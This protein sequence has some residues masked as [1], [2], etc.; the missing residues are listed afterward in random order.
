[1]AISRVEFFSP[2]MGQHV[3]YSIYLPDV[4]EGP[5][6]VLFQLHGLTDSHTAWIQYSRIVKHA[7]NYPMVIVFPDGGTGAYLNWLGHERIGKRMYE[8]LI[9]T[10][11]ANH[12]HRHYNV[13]DGP[14][15]IGGLSM[16]GYGS[17]RLG[18]KYADRF[19]S[20]WSHSSKFEWEGMIESGQFADP[21]DTDVRTHADAVNAMADKPVI[22]FDCGTEDQLIEESRRFHEHLDE[23]GLDHTYNEHSGGHTWEYWDEHVQPAL[24]QHARVLG[25]EPIVE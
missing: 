18:L 12:L 9:I 13:T 1:M 25:I 7:A 17:M 20:I 2:A 15:A 3:S 5:F 11:I 24:A 19:K 10:D 22:T 6:P 14:W 4:G 21:H 23:I 16:G 8:D